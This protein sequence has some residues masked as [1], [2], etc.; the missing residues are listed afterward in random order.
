MDLAAALVR[1]ISEQA[2]RDVSAKLSADEA[3]RHSTGRYQAS[4]IAGESR[5]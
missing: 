4:P 1:R 2:L 5:A 3:R